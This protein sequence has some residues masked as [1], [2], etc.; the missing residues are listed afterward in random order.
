MR[1]RDRVGL[2]FPP[3]LL[4][5]MLGVI[6]LW[7][8]LGKILEKFEVQ[9]SQAAILANMGAFTPA[10]ATPAPPKP[11]TPPAAPTTAPEPKP[12]DGAQAPASP[13]IRLTSQATG[14]KYRS[15]DFPTPVKVRNLYALALT[16][17]GAA[18]PGATSDG[19]PKM[20]TW[21]QSLA[22]DNWPVYLAWTAAILEVLSGIGLLLGLLTRLWALSMAAR[23]FAAIWITQIGPAIQTGDTVLGFL[24]AHP[25]FDLEKW[26]PLAFL[27]CLLM[28]SLA[29]LFL[30]PGRA[31]LDHAIF[32]PS[33]PD[34]DD[35]DGE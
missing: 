21:P 20:P 1:V 19:S 2:N 26:R 6:L 4:R 16:I 31:S 3:L 15:A 18:E 5:T 29:L 24:P 28:S 33:Q 10:S 9:G 11:A 34:D 32:A 17:K 12:K 22:S 8:G 25:T 7:M 13:T 27:F 30:G 14:P 23:M 35:E